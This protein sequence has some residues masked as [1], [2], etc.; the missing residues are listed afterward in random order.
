MRLILAIGD[1]IWGAVQRKCMLTHL[2]SVG[3]HLQGFPT[4]FLHENSEGF[5]I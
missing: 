2:A 5:E 4:A 1:D 3:E